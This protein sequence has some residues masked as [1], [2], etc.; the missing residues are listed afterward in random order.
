MTKPT[1]DMGAAEQVI[2]EA[3]VRAGERPEPER[4]PRPESEESDEL[5]D[6]LGDR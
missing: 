1:G 4:E 6:D 3:R 5:P 2:G